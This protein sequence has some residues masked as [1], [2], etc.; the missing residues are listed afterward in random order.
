MQCNFCQA[1]CHHLR[2]GLLKTI[3]VHGRHE[4]DAGAVDEVDDGFIALLVLV[5][6]VLSQVDDQLS[7]HC[8]IAMHVSYVFKLRLTCRDRKKESRYGV[9]GGAE[10]AHTT[11]KPT[12]SNKFS[13]SELE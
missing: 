7:A 11:F 1:T 4:M 5:A 9:T 8:L 6:K 10:T 12:E 2:G 3:W 13:R